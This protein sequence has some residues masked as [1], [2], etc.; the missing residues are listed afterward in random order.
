MKKKFKGFIDDIAFA[1]EE[2]KWAII[3]AAA[4]IC[5]LSLL[6]VDSYNKHYS[7]KALDQVSIAKAYRF[8][9]NELV[10]DASTK[11]VYIKAP[12]GEFLPYYS[13]NGKLCRYEE[14][15]FVEVE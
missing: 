14:G 1:F 15:T 3:I 7:E 5:L 2:Y 6:T 12:K 11:I 13:E 8:T 4:L 10:Y 9:E